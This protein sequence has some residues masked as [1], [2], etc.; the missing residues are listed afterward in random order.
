MA[1]LNRLTVD[2]LA[3]SWSGVLL[4]R[5]TIGAWGPSQSDAGAVEVHSFGQS[6]EIWVTSLMEAEDL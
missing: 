1:A 2:A 4:T 5:A 3:L 6:E